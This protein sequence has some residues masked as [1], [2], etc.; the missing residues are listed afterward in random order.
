[1]PIQFRYEKLHARSVAPDGRQD[2]V[3]CLEVR[4]DPLL[5]TSSRIAEG[6]KLQTADAAV[7]ERFQGPDASCPFCADRVDLATPRI[8]SHVSDELRIRSGETVLFPNL[9][10]YSQH[11]AVAIFTPRHWLGVNEFSPKLLADNL[12]ACIRY[13]RAVHASDSRARY[14][15]WNVNYLFPSGGSL[16]HPHAQV[17]LDPIPTTMMRFQFEAGERYW[18][19]NGTSYWEDLVAMER[20]RNE[21]FVWDIGSTAWMTAFAPIGFNEVRA[22]IRDRETLLQLNHADVAAI[23]A[24]ISRVLQWYGEVGYN[25]FNVSLFSGPFE[26]LASF[27]VNLAMVTRTAM[28]PYYRSDAMY[29]ERLH[30]EAT[31]DRAPEAIAVELRDHSHDRQAG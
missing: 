3:R 22:V 31:V 26:G 21:R 20:E 10:P 7:L 30:W 2:N 4:F 14:C 29:L 11:A 12:D 18:Q 19:E 16:P 24:G 28:L 5:G 17:F 27:R 23:A 6:V 8:D 25:S 13:I 15:A 1:M 9:V